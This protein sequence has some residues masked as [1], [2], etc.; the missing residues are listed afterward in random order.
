M[1]FEEVGRIITGPEFLSEIPKCSLTEYLISKMKS[2]PKENIV[3]VWVQIWLK[4]F[5]CDYLL[6]I[7]F[8]LILKLVIHKHVANFWI[9]F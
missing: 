5:L 4:I 2:Q 8:R 1:G 7:I 3:Q 6:R 9:W